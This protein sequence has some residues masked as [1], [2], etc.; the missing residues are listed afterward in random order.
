MF[1]TLLADK[2]VLP[3][4]SEAMYSDQAYILLGFALENITGNSYAD[5]IKDLITRPLGL[6]STGYDRPAA[7]KAIIPLGMD[8]YNLDFGNFKS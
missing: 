5:I 4:A 6:K 3:P 7:S 1:K 8:W 2:P